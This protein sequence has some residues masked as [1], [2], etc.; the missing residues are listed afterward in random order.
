[1]QQSVHLISEPQEVGQRLWPPSSPIQGPGTARGPRFAAGPCRW[2][3]LRGPCARQRRGPAFQ[4][5]NPQASWGQHKGL[6]EAREAQSRSWDRSVECRAA[7]GIQELSP[8]RGRPP[9]GGVRDTW[10]WG[11]WAGPSWAPGARPRWVAL[12]ARRGG[13][14]DCRLPKARAELQPA[15]LC[16]SALGCGLGVHCP[17]SGPRPTRAQGRQVEQSRLPPGGHAHDGAQR[18][19]A[20]DRLVHPLRPLPPRRRLLHDPALLR[21]GQCGLRGSDLES[22][23]FWS[24]GGPEAAGARPWGPQDAALAALGLGGVRPLGGEGG[25]SPFPMLT[26]ALVS[27]SQ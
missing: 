13:K 15:G 24:V 12:E 7:G 21:Q 5:Q 1:M 14:R 9:G 4:T 25:R 19:A 27:G 16:P 20:L 6:S 18:L 2:G 10:G 11:R 23:A 8:S 22:R 3:S 26:S 17:P